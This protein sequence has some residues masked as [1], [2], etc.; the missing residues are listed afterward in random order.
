MAK[1]RTHDRWNTFW[2]TL[3][4]GFLWWLGLRWSL[5]GLFFL[6]YFFGTFVFSPD[7]D[8]GPKKRV[9]LMGI[10]LYPYQFFFRHRG[11]SHSLFLGTLTRVLYLIIMSAI[12]LWVLRQ[13]GY[14][15]WSVEDFFSFL[16]HSLKEFDYARPEYQML[17]WFFLGHFFSDFCH[18]VLDRISS[19]FKK[20]W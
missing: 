4:L 9:G 13:M 19:F 5:I 3:T 11:V 18:I 12:F 14:F 20:W 17:S 16:Y 2:L 1:G 6:G 10:V 8:L 15:A 7:T